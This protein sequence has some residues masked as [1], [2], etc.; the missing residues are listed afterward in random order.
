MPSS[1]DVTISFRHDHAVWSLDVKYASILLIALAVCATAV[2]AP[3][4]ADAI[5]HDPPMDRD[6]PAS[7]SALRIA[8]HGQQMNALV[9]VPAGAGPHPVALLLH[10]FPGNEQNLDLAQAMRR[11]GWTVVTF[12]YR[13]SWG[14]EGTF[15]FDGAVEDGMAVSDWIRSG[16]HAASVR[17]DPK[18]MVVI[19][20]SMGGFVAANVCAAHAGLLG[21][22]LIAPW[23]LSM[24]QAL[25][26]KL[27]PAER[28]RT[29]A[30]DFNDVD[31]R[32]AGMTARSAI[33]DLAA[34]GERW[35]LAATAPAVARHDTLIVV[36][37]RDGE[38]CRALRLI[39]ALKA[40]HASALRVETIE[41][42]HG[43]NDHRIALE[44]MVLDWLAGLK[45]PAPKP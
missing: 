6:K 11:A 32:I 15:S 30:S 23:D 31:G 35:S 39:P 34:H 7:S 1:H 44:T 27:S 10:G 8:S 20:H 18:R 22:A 16:D 5:A 37:G 36:A 9:Y 29:A 26:A 28:D 3:P 24:D 33:D 45:Q 14:S 42:D 25:L 40:Q 12:H 2:A 38:D 19:G 17:G 43:F 41:S 13:G 21:C 4:A